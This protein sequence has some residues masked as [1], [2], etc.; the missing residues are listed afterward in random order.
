MENEWLCSQ[1][2]R[3]HGIEV[4]QCWMETF[5]EQKTLVVERFDRRLASDGSWYLRLP[6]EDLCQATATPPG[7]KYES[8][9]GPGMGAIMELLLGSE[10]AAELSR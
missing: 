9:G 3:A 4:A 7:L 1:I 2:V 10:Q 6:Q 8:D 5:G